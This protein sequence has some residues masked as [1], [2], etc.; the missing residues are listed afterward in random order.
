MDFVLHV[1][2]LIWLVPTSLNGGGA[3]QAGTDID[4]PCPQ[5]L[6]KAPAKVPP[7]WVVKR[8]AGVNP[9]LCP[10]L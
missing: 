6:A 1:G 3:L 8:E 4:K 2:I 10:Q 9:A 5:T 7:A